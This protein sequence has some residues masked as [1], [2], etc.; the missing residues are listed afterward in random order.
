M[1]SPQLHLLDKSEGREEAL[2]LIRGYL[3]E[4]KKEPEDNAQWLHAVRASGWRGAIYHLWW[5]AS[6]SPAFLLNALFALT[7]VPLP[8]PQRALQFLGRAGIT[9]SAL[10]LH[11]KKV[12]HRAKK[13]GRDHLAELLGQ[14]PENPLTL[15]GFSLGAL[16]IY[17]GLMSLT[18]RPSFSIRDVI[19]LGGTITEAKK[20][21]WEKAI[22]PVEG[23]LINVFNTRDYMLR[24]I[25]R[26]GQLNP[27]QPCGLTPI[28]FD[29]PR[30]LNVD[31]TGEISGSPKNHWEHVKALPTTIGWLYDGDDSVGFKAAPLSRMPRPSHG[32]SLK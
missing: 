29:H 15:M 12:K 14:V 21:Q 28:P 18:G 13:V 16:I 3:S 25:F 31:A 11:W 10:L 2:V 5:D 8:P 27:K 26:L 24:Y 17:D 4:R 7:R 23:T 30:I 22:E 6:S 32:I 19:L 9:A 1:K 20:R